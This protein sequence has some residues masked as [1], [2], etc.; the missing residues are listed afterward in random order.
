MRGLVVPQTPCYRLQ[1]RFYGL[2]VA[3]C[4]VNTRA[5]V[6]LMVHLKPSPPPAPEPLTPSCRLHG[7]TSFRSAERAGNFYR[8][9]KAACTWFLKCRLPKKAGILLRFTMFPAFHGRHND[10]GFHHP[11]AVQG[12]PVKKQFDIVRQPAPRTYAAHRRLQSAW[13]AAR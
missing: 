13:R 8:Q 11:A 4:C 7:K 1:R 12:Y 3:I 2:S 10:W 9:K 6:R 5:R